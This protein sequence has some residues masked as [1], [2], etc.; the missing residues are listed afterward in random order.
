MRFRC[1]GVVIDISEFVQK[2]NQLALQN[3]L[4]I[5]S[6]LSKHNVDKTIE[7]MLKR[8]IDDVFPFV[9][10]DDYSRRDYRYENSYLQLRNQYGSSLETDF[11]KA[12]FEVLTI[13]LIPSE[14]ITV[15]YYCNCLVLKKNDG[16]SW[17]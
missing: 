11:S 14:R 3:S 16:S 2:I 1:T 9:E 10:I 15:T 4:V 8:L 12:L 5:G 6:Y 13:K 17:F 7:W